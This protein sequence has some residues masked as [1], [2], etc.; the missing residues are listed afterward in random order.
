M[1][2]VVSP[3][4]LKAVTNS[5]GSVVLATWEVHVYLDP[6]MA[7]PPGRYA[8][9]AAAQADMVPWPQSQVEVSL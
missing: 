1:R 5:S 2:R 6:V 3:K 8:N 9:G 4:A 7:V